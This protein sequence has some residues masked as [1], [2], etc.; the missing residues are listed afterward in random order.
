M[1][2]L[3][4]S[5]ENNNVMFIALSVEIKNKNVLGSDVIGLKGR[6]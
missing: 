6:G 3:V 5:K 2:M 1:E 4:L